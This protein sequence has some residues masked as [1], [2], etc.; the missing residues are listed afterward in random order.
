MRRLQ[1]TRRICYDSAWRDDGEG[2]RVTEACPFDVPVNSAAPI[3]SAT[4]MLLLNETFGA[5]SWSI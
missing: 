1:Q 5:D 3:V 4:Q 2:Q